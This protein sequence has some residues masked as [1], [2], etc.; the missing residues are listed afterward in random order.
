MKKELVANVK[1]VLRQNKEWVAKLNRPI[2]S[3]D[4]IDSAMQELKDLLKIEPV[5]K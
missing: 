2:F 1:S 5:L 4:N 3:D